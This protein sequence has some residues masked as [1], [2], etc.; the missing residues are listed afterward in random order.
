MNRIIFFS[1]EG[2]D[3]NTQIKWMTEYAEDFGNGKILGI[4]IFFFNF[5]K[6]ECI[7]LISFINNGF[8]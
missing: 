8:S 5:I 4:V 6:S 7:V 3:L 1:R 2:G